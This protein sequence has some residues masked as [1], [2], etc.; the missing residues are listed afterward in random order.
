MF[1]TVLLLA[2]R[3][4]TSTTPQPIFT[5]DAFVMDYGTIEYNADG[6]RELYY[7]NTGNAPLVLSVKSSCGCLVPYYPKEPT[8]PGKRDKIGARYDT[9]RAGIFQ[10]TLTVTTNES[11]EGKYHVIQIKGT[12][13]AAPSPADLSV[14][15]ESR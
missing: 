10:K 5:P 4:A 11:E 7:T 15:T 1:S 6:Y 14:P 12:V 9:R 8:L 3:L 2:L 13:K